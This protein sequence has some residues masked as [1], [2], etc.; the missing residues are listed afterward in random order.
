MEEGAYASKSA[1]GQK[2][3]DAA[4]RP[5]INSKQVRGSG[6]LEKSWN[7]WLRGWERELAQILK[8]KERKR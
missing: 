2:R 5:G 8:K 4:L 7:L 3:Y 1:Q 6:F